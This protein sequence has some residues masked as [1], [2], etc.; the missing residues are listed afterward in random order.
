MSLAADSLP[1]IKINL[2]SWILHNNYYIARAGRKPGLSTYFQHFNRLRSGMK[3]WKTRIA[4]VMAVLLV[5]IVMLTGWF[6]AF[7]DRKRCDHW[8][9]YLV[10]SRVISFGSFFW[11]ILFWSVFCRLIFSQIVAFRFSFVLYYF[12]IFPEDHSGDMIVWWCRW[13]R[14]ES[15]CGYRDSLHVYWIHY[16]A[17]GTHCTVTRFHCTALRT[18]CTAPGTHC[19]VSGTRCNLLLLIHLWKQNQFIQW[20]ECNAEGA[21]TPCVPRLWIPKECLMPGWVTKTVSRK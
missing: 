15:L 16:T 9:I 2:H 5:I 3:R 11:A 14:R 6:F 18:R 8:S 10:I 13:W 12:L 20:K 19:K 21:P 7:F 4:A 1:G 17:P